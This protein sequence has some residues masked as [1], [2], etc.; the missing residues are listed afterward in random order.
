MSRGSASLS[1]QILAGLAAGK[2]E[3]QVETSQAKHIFKVKCFFL[4]KKK[5]IMIL[6]EDARIFSK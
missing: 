1:P 4:K 5:K 3:K 2:A 6:L